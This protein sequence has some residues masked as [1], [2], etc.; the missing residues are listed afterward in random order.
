MSY[1]TRLAVVLG[2]LALAACS[3]KP[4]PE[5]ISAAVRENIPGSIATLAQFDAAEAE[6]RSEGEGFLVTFKAHLKTKEALYRLVDPVKVAA[7]VG[8]VLSLSALEEVV[9]TTPP[10]VTEALANDLKPLLARPAFFEPTAAAGTPIEW[11]GSMRMKK[12]VDKWVTTEVKSEVPPS[13]PGAP[14]ALIPPDAVELSKAKDWF[15]DREKQQRF[16]VQRLADATKVKSAEQ[17]A[18]RAE[19]VAQRERELR[20]NVVA[21]VQQHARQLPIRYGFRRAAFGGTE[22]LELQSNTAITLRMEVRRGYQ[23]LV[24]DLQ[25]VPGRTLSFGHIEGWGFRSGDAVRL[26]NG[27]FDPTTFTAP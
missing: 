21:A 11:Y 23:Q 12:V 5:D 19:A 14:R 6:S 17:G 20:D 2:A 1:T 27:A 3:P 7:D 10:E 13:I 18:A 22:V 8:A 9:R 24:R 16:M 15:S 4:G 26:T 25:V